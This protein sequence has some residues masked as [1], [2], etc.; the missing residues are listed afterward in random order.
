MASLVFGDDRSRCAPIE[1]V[2]DTGADDAA[3]EARRGM[4]GSNTPR[5][6]S[7]GRY[8]VNLVQEQVGMYRAENFATAL[9]R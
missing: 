3:V 5:G 6:R 4:H 7:T 8:K 2:V 9:A 1:V